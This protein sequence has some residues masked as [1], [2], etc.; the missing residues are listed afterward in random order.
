[1][2]VV[3]EAVEWVANVRLAKAYAETN[4][5]VHVSVDRPYSPIEQRSYSWFSVAMVAA[6]VSLV[7]FFGIRIWGVG[8]SS[9]ELASKAIV[10]ETRNDL[11]KVVTAWSDLQSDLGDESGR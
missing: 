3:A 5:S 7:S 9:R 6:S 8:A 1:M 2:Q 10:E 11:A 4:D